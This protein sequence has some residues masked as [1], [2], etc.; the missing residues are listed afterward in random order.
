M[1][2]RVPPLNCTLGEQDLR[3]RSHESYATTSSSSVRGNGARNQHCRRPGSNA[4]QG[5]H[6]VRVVNTCNG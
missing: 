5:Q 4:R 3:A 2:T 1:T 6:M